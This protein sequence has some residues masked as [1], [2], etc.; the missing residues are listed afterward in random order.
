MRCH[1]LDVDEKRSAARPQ[2]PVDREQRVLEIDAVALVD[3]GDALRSSIEHL[4]EPDRFV[5][6]VVGE[7]MCVEWKEQACAI[8]TILSDCGKVSVSLPVV[9][10]CTKVR[11]LPKN[12][13][14]MPA[15]SEKSVTH[16]TPP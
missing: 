15:I 1:G 10:T 13:L 16:D 4:V 12:R 2:M 8:A 11:G 9:K 3:G 6:F 7:E 14:E 5:K